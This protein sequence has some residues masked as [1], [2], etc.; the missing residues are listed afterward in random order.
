M[1]SG[2]IG[3]G[4]AEALFELASREGAQQD[5]A[6][7][8]DQ[9]VRLLHEE[10]RVRTF[11]EA[12]T[13]DREDKKRALRAALEGH[14][15]RLFLNF[16]LVVIDKRRQRLLTEMARQYHVLLDEH[17]GRLHADVTLARE[18]DEAL[19]RDIASSLSQRLGRTVVPHVHVD[20]RIIGGLIV[21]WGDRVIDGSV[22]HRLVSL[23]RRL[24][25]ADLPLEPEPHGS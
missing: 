4:Y 23:R 9:V 14:V 6:D 16:L 20:P 7:A 18:P 21:R 10:P 11:V 8:F 12:P 3:R 22:R 1:E 25:S 24:L 19:E 2:T 13:V 17:T 15:P 5:F